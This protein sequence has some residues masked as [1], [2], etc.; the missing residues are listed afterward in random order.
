MAIPF[1]I[2]LYSDTQIFGF[3]WWI[4]R[5]ICQGERPFCIFVPICF[6]YPGRFEG[7]YN[8][9]LILLSGKINPNVSPAISRYLYTAEL[10]NFSANKHQQTNDN[11][12]LSFRHNRDRSLY[13][14]ISKFVPCAT[15]CP[16]KIAHSAVEVEIS[17]D[18]YRCNHI[19]HP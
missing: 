6:V 1:K 19:Y 17:N 12:R 8:L 16:I 13:F 2:R 9:C 14:N 4:E 7:W 10:V 18:M 5:Y 3:F 11:R 15:N